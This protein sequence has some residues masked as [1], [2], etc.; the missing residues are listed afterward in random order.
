MFQSSSCPVH[1]LF[2]VFSTMRS[3]SWSH[4][5]RRTSGAKRYEE[6]ERERSGAGWNGCS[7]SSTHSKNRGYHVLDSA[8]CPRM[9]RSELTGPR[10][11]VHGVAWN[12]RKRGG[13]RERLQREAEEEEEG[14]GGRCSTCVQVASFRFAVKVL[15]FVPRFESCRRSRRQELV[16]KPATLTYLASTVHLYSPYCQHVE[17][18]RN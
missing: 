9:P 5:H 13:R 10:F 3:T 4:M 15:S 16:C 7:D 1:K 18:R 11:R 14:D 17:F 6:R 2:L 8:S 12:G